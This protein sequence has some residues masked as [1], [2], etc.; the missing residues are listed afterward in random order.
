MPQYPLLI[1]PQT[2]KKHLDDE[3][4]LI[5]DLCKRETYQANHVPGAIHFDYSHIVKVDKPIMGLVPDDAKLVEI[6]S[7]LGI[8]NNIHVVAYDDE[9]GGKACR[10][11]WTL[12]LAGHNKLS[13]LNGGIFSWANSGLPL[14]QTESLPSPSTFETQK[15]Q[16]ILATLEYIQANLDNEQVQL[17]DSRSL[18]EYRGSKVYALKGGHIPGAIHYEWTDAMDRNNNLC[19]LPINEIE[20]TLLDKGVDKDKTI[21]AYCHSHHRSS[22]SYYVLKMAGYKN[23]KGYAGSWS[24]W[25]NHPDTEVEKLS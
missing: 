13:L 11:M 2:L 10:F 23:I 24:E 3:N 6:F 22:Y 1:E 7:S 25:G 21:V 8:D 9:G 20:Q 16:S 14:S 17:L 15:N 12:E 5:I 18:A 19:M 4:L